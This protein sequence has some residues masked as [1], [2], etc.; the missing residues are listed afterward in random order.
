[1]KF[2][3]G[4]M[5]TIVAVSLAACGGGGAWSPGVPQQSPTPPR[6]I[7]AAATFS[8]TIPLRS[9]PAPA[10]AHRD[11]VSQNTRSMTAAVNGGTPQAIG[12]TAATNPNCTGDGI[13]IPIVCKNLS[14]SANPGDDT[15]TF[16][17][18]KDTLVQ[19]AEPPNATLLSS[20]TTAVEHI[21][22][23]ANNA[24]GTFTANPVI[25][26]VPIALAYPSGGFGIGVIG[27]YPISVA[28]KDPTGATILGA[29]VFTDANGNPVSITVTTDL[30]APYS[31][32]ISFAA[33]GCSATA[34]TSFAFTFSGQTANVI[35]LG[36]VHPLFYF[37][38]TGGGFSSSTQIPGAPGT[39]SI[40]LTCTQSFDACTNGT[41]P[42][43]SFAQIGDTATIAFSEPGWTN[44]PFSQGLTL[45]SDTCNTTD[46]PNATGNWATFSP[47]LGSVAT[48]FTV[49]ATGAGTTATPAIC[50]ATFSDLMGNTA[51]MS[52]QVTASSVGIQ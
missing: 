31:G 32:F 36:G 1:M 19:G 8:I 49:T 7:P 52:V 38:A 4:F 14:V 51:T 21:V 23:G 24:L 12:L 29:G 17:L 45:A 37:T 27:C 11:Y 2:F 20:Y 35:T 34:Q 13:T 39:P 25:G 30:S 44:A 18:Y 22:S 3:I 47:G 28:A 26:G 43:A 16:K 9:S 5:S 40:A 15:F 42:L 33:S 41:L 6:G 10:L 50:K 48:G 46:N